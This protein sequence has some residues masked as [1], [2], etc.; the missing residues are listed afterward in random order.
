LVWLK[1]LLCLAAILI[2]GTRLARFADIIAEKTGLGRIWIGLA[3]VALVTA[4]PEMA[5]GVSAA[6]L[7]K[8][9]D[10]AMGTLIGSCCFNL[11]IL[12]V[13]DHIGTR[14][15]VLANVSK[16]HLP[17][18]RAGLALLSVAA[19]GLFLSHRLAL[20]MLA[21]LSIPAIILLILYPLSLRHILMRERDSGAEDGEE[22]AAEHY[23]S[24][25]LRSAL[26]GFFTAAAVVIAAGVWLSFI[27]DEI[28]A[29]TGWGTSFVGNLL[30]AVATSAP[31]VVVSVTAVRLGFPDIAVADILGANM[32]DT[33]M[34][35]LVD[36]FYIRGSVFTDASPV[37]LVVMLV[38]LAST[39]MVA[40]GI[41]KRSRRYVIGRL[42]WY[43][44]LLV[45]LYLAAAYVLFA[46]GSS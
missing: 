43:G 21:W 28:A 15:P 39:A 29:V 20:P 25:T 32:L 5:T 6:A 30:L 16:R 33:G 36:L 24:T 45:G 4:T 18:A 26:T 2:A 44:P 9:P 3:L 37:N 38:A 7:V 19:I 13:L 23:G 40:I 35:G 22:E 17:G 14:G 11:S 46:W 31:E 41:W 10:L 42:T 12:F 27:G 1:F 8:S 34:L